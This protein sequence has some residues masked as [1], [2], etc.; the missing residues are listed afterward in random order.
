MDWILILLQNDNYQLAKIMMMIFTGE[1]AMRMIRIKS[2]YCYDDILYHKLGQTISMEEHSQKSRVIRT[3][4][5][6]IPVLVVLFLFDYLIFMNPTIESHLGRHLWNLLNLAFG[7][8]DI[9]LVRVCHCDLLSLIIYH[10][11]LL[12]Q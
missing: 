6:P 10:I 2:M 4:F 3:S 8:Y 1:I 11:L 9:L 12:I 5:E 7:H